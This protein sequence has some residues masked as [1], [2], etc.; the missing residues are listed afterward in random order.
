MCCNYSIS[1]GCPTLDLNER[2]GYGTMDGME[3]KKEAEKTWAVFF[4]LMF[5]VF[6][7]M[8]GAIVGSA[9]VA[10]LTMN[11]GEVMEQYDTCSLCPNPQEH[12]VCVID[13]WTSYYTIKHCVS[14]EK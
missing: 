4:F 13:R 12:R 5:M 9:T 2:A 7:G 6:F 8:L 11:K 3:N 1:I 10:G 14:K